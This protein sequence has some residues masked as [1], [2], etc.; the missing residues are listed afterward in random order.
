MK[1]DTFSGIIEGIKDR[2]AGWKART[3]SFVGR[4]ALA[5]A[6]LTTIPYYT[7]QTTLIPKGVIQ[8]IERLSRNF[9]WGEVEGERRCHLVNWETVTLS[10]DQGGLGIRRLREM[11]LAFLA[12][13]GLRIMNDEECLWIKMMKNKYSI[14]DPNPTT[15]RPKANMSNAWKGIVE[16]ITIL[17]AGT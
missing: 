13:L 8:S 14:N 5:Q 11:N 12:K 3:L 1:R 15:W 9:L 7:M 16:S 6:T 4:H 2:L 17:Q 10:K